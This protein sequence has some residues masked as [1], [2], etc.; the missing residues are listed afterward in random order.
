[1]KWWRLWTS[2]RFRYVANSTRSSYRKSASAQG[3]TSAFTS[4]RNCRTSRHSFF[5]SLKTRHRPSKTLAA[6]GTLCAHKF[7]L[8]SSG[9]RSGNVGCGGRQCYH[10]VNESPSGASRDTFFCSESGKRFSLSIAV[11]SACTTFQAKAPVSKR[12]GPR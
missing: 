5:R 12:V 7:I 9:S 3:P 11:W 6:P 4:L 10:F 2:P 8:D 1:M